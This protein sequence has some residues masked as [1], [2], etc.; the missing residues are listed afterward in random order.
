MSNLRDEIANSMRS[1]MRERWMGK[2]FGRESTHQRGLRGRTMRGVVEPRRAGQGG[3]EPPASSMK[4][5]AWTPVLALRETAE[6]H[7]ADGDAKLA[8][9]TGR[10]RVARAP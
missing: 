7:A 6:Q 3:V 5:E 10:E 9:G 4:L 1:A 2:G 8:E